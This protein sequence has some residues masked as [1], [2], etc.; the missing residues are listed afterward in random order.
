MKRNIGNCQLIIAAAFAAFTSSAARAQIELSEELGA[1]TFSYSDFGFEASARGT[2][3]ATTMPTVNLNFSELGETTL[4]FELSAPEGQLLEVEVPETSWDDG[5]FA[6]RYIIEQGNSGASQINPAV[7]VEYIDGEGDLPN[8]SSQTASLLNDTNRIYVMPF[9]DITAGQTFRF[10]AMRVSLVVPESY[11]NTLSGVTTQFQFL[12]NLSAFDGSP[13]DPGE[14]IRFVD[15]P[16][17]TPVVLPRAT[18]RALEKKIEAKLKKLKTKMRL[19]SRG[20]DSAR[21]TRMKKKILLL[22][23]VLN[24]A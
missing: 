15:A 17:P 23:A 24:R 19:L 14:W 21:I 5:S 12:L 3:S 13:A 7:T 10:R 4:T 22:Q 8:F 6:F 20:E 11:S 2:V 1:P 16:E 18:P 9:T